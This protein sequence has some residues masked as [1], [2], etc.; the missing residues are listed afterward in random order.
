MKDDIPFYR[1]LTQS[2]LLMKSIKR[3]QKGMYYQRR[4]LQIIEH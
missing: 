4:S 1:Y 3:K 2:G